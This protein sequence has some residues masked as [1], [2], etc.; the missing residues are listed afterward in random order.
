VVGGPKHESRAQQVDC[1]KSEI[2]SSGN[3]SSMLDHVKKLLR[4]FG[5][6]AHRYTIQ[7]SAGAQ[8]A[9]LIKLS[10]I[11]LVLDVGA[12]IGQYASFIRAHG[13]RG[14]I[15]SFEPL[16][17]AHTRLAAY[18]CV[19][20]QWRVAPRMALG[21]SEGEVTIHVARNSISSSVLE[22]LPEHEH[23]APGSGFVNSEIVPG[24]RLDRVVIDY[25]LASS[26]VLLK[27]DT[28]GYED[29]VL[30]GA[31]GVLDRICAIQTELSLVPLYAGQP[32]FDEM[33][34]KIESSGFVLAA[35]FPGYVDPATGRTLQVDGFFLRRDTVQ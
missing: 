17:S 32:L 31:Q 33:R 34:A 26:V 12:N 21:D 3:S 16:S 2:G 10:G 15:V 9:H 35:I 22:M 7:T 8:L 30:A 28:Q 13:Y 23:A 19:D 5:F 1:S 14:E 6:E 4:Y 18:A 20:P 27:M 25:L 11:N 24:G 29:R